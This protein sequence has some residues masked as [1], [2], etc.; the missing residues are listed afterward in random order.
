VLRLNSQYTEGVDLTAAAEYGNGERPSHR[1]NAVD[2]RLS[3]EPVSVRR[4]HRSCLWT[5]TASTRDSTGST[6]NGDGDA[7]EQYEYAPVTNIIGEINWN[8]DITTNTVL[9]SVLKSSSP[10]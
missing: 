1:R 9:N 2:Q 8:Y 5:S 6:L 4:S 3:S 10:T 7:Y